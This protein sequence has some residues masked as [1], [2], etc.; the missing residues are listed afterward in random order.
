MK[1]EELVQ[2]FKEKRVAQRLRAE[3][4]LV[5]N[6]EK[7]RRTMERYTY[8][9]RCTYSIIWLVQLLKANSYIP[10]FFSIAY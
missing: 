5:T 6:M 3:E 8:Y 1:G 10:G 2:S 4:K 9:D 7:A